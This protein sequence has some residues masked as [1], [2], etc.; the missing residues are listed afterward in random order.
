MSASGKV[1]IIDNTE[2][3]LLSDSEFFM[4]GGLSDLIANNQFIVKDFPVNFEDKLSVLQTTNAN[5]GYL[6]KI[7]KRDKRGQFCTE[8]RLAYKNRLKDINETHYLFIDKGMVEYAGLEIVDR[9]PARIEP[10]DKDCIRKLKNNL[11]EFEV[12]NV[13]DW[14][15]GKVM[16]LI[17]DLG[18]INI[19]CDNDNAAL[20]AFVTKLY[21]ADTETLI[22]TDA[23]SEYNSSYVARLLIGLNE[24]A[25]RVQFVGKLWHR[26][27]V[28]NDCEVYLWFPKSEDSINDRIYAS[29]TLFS[30]EAINYAGTSKKPM[31]V[32]YEVTMLDLA[33]SKFSL[34]VVSIDGLE[35]NDA[36]ILM[37]NMFEKLKLV[38]QTFGLCNNTSLE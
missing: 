7:T 1:I 32:T 33:Y 31:G 37:G 14:E 26:E 28:L 22:N 16:A 5:I 3:T 23:V 13:S 10:T 21:L 2:A 12:L 24:K 9:D 30:E 38:L 11:N 6:T 15:P 29:F 34:R 8:V 19:Y 18:Y 25:D 20:Y 4:I 27:L 17:S 36:T 35:A